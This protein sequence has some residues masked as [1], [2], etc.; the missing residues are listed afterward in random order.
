MNDINHACKALINKGN[1]VVF[2]ELLEQAVYLALKLHLKDRT[3]ALDVRDQ[4]AVSECGHDL[5]S[6]KVVQ[7]VGNVEANLL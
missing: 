2:L 6:R 5:A 3:V 7:L 4:R 1:A